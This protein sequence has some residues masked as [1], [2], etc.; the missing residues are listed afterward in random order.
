VELVSEGTTNFAGSSR[1]RVQNIVAAANRFRN[2]VVPPGAEFSFNEH[3]GEINAESGFVDSY[4]IWGDRTA[5][6]IGGG[7]CQVSTTAFRAA[8]YGGFPITERWAHGYVVS[9]YGEPGLDATIFTPWVDLRFRNDTGKFLLIKA[10]VDTA[11]SS[12]A[13]RF[14]GTKPAR[15]VEMDKPEI[16]NTRA[17]EGPIYQEDL[18]LAAGVL[19]QVEWA[20]NGM[21]VVIT[22]RVRTADGQV[23]EDVFRSEYQPW[24]SLFLVG[25]GVPVPEGAKIVPVATPTPTPRP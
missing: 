5:V 18:T 25:P 14:Y 12:I 4:I 10:S 15:T 8:F 16:S 7:V 3:V 23:R 9:W 2:V 24:R 6:G 22:R 13:F 21:D 19:K 20:R 11:R 1:E 17:P